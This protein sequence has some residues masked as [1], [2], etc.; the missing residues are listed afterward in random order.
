[1]LS[2]SYHKEREEA[3]TS[4]L[5]RFADTLCRLPAEHD[6]FESVIVQMRGLCEQMLYTKN[7]IRRDTAK[8]ETVSNSFSGL[9]N[10]YALDDQ[11]ST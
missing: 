5:K 2:L 1:M 6:G 7:Q 9:Q 4:E 11:K 8:P 10:D 3:L